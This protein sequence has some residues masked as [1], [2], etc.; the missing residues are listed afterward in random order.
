MWEIKL[1]ETPEEREQVFK[2]RY[3][4]C[5][6][7]MGKN[8]HYADH[9]HKRLEEPL[10]SSAK[11]F[12]AYQNDQVIGT[13]RNNLAASSNLEYYSQLYK[14]YET[15]GDAHPHYT[16][17]ST[18]LMI[19]KEFRASTLFLDLFRALYKHLLSEGIKFDFGDC[20]FPVTIFFKRLGYQVVG[21]ANHPEY[22]E[23]NIVMLDV[24]NLEHLEK[25]NSPFKGIYKTFINQKLP[26][27][28][29]ADIL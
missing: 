24:L 10:D 16:S 19:Q 1:A 2:L 15:V 26:L 28:K 23:G 18:K 27:I 7:E 22:G 3:S 4:I 25:S 9:K 17:I 5:V 14:M 6:E 13:I 11:I 29:A 20:D 21:Q 8:Q 12:A